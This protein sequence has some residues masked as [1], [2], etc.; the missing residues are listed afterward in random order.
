MIDILQCMRDPAVFG[1]AFRDPKTW[2]AWRAFLATS[3]GL[4]MTPEMSR[5]FTECTGRTTPP[6]GGSKEAVLIVGRRGGKSFVLALI[7]TFLA[8]FKDYRRY[9]VD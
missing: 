6:K 8:T 3:F 1:N 4:R 7:A 2:I 9:L 5:I